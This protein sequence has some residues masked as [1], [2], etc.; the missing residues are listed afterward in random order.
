MR[1]AFFSRSKR[2]LFHHYIPHNEQIRLHTINYLIR[3]GI[4]LVKLKK[5]MPDPCKP[6]S[7][8]RNVDHFEN[9]KSQEGM[10]KDEEC[11]SDA[12][13]V[14]TLIGFALMVFEVLLEERVLGDGLLN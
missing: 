3:L 10:H 7:K 1:I 14:E 5:V 11:Q 8:Y 4:R 2:P 13:D 12:D 9:V 6:K